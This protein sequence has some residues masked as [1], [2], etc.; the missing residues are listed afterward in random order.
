V[1]TAD[2]NAK[3]AGFDCAKLDATVNGSTA[4]IRGHVSREADLQRI[5]S[6]LSSLGVKTVNRSAVQVVPP[7]HCQ[8]ATA[9]A[10]F[11]GDGSDAPT[12]ALKNGGTAAFEGQKLVTTLAA[13]GFP[14]YVYA[15]LY[16]TEG[17][18]VHMMPNPKER[19]NRVEAKQRTVLGE[20]GLFG[21]QWDLVPPFGKHMLVVMQSQSPLF[22][23]KTRPEVEKSAAYLNALRDDVAKMPSGDKFV[24][25]YTVF[26]FQPKK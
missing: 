24:V 13:A 5:N 15:D 19:N 10:P 7:P 2:V 25:N 22:L 23:P 1:S 6:E 9:L 20:D 11:T 12:I 21:M 14:G 18:V 3:L 4:N 16:D 17:N 8:I 26:D